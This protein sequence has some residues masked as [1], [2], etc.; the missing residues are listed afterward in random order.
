M[1]DLVV[2]NQAGSVFLSQRSPHVMIYQDSCKSPIP[3]LADC[4]DAVNSW[5]WPSVIDD[6]GEN[7]S[8][9]DR[10]LRP[11]GCYLRNFGTDTDESYRFFFNSAG[12]N[13]GLCTSDY[14]CLCFSLAGDAGWKT[15]VELISTPWFLPLN[16][17]LGMRGAPNMSTCVGDCDDDSDCAD[18]LKCFQR[19]ED[20]RV[21][22]CT[23][24]GVRAWD[25]CYNESVEEVRSDVMPY[26]AD[27]DNDGAVDLLLGHLDGRV[28]FYQRGLGN[29]LTLITESIV[30]IFGKSAMPVA[31]DLDG[32]GDLDLIVGYSGSSENESGYLEYFE[33]V[34]SRG[35][36]TLVHRSGSE[37]PFKFIVVGANLVPRIADWDG[38]GDVDLI[39][40][41]RYGGIYYFEQLSGIFV[42]R[43]ADG[44][45]FDGLNA[46]PFASITPL[47]LDG[48]GFLDLVS[49]CDD[50]YHRMWFYYSRHDTDD[51][52]HMTNNMNP[53]NN[54]HIRHAAPYFVDWDGDGDLDLLVGNLQGN[55]QY[56]QKQGDGTHV[57]LIGADN[58]FVGFEFG[59]SAK[60]QAVD[61]DGDGD[62]DVIVGCTEL[63]SQMGRIEYLERKANGSLVQMRGSSNPFVNISMLRASAP[64]AVDWDDDGDLDLIVPAH[65]A[66]QG[67]DKLFIFERQA[68]Q[69]LIRQV[70]GSNRFFAAQAIPD[71]TLVNRDID[72]LTS[73]VPLATDWNGD[74]RLD[75]LLGGIDGVV[76]LAKQH[77]SKGKYKFR[78]G[79]KASQIFCTVTMK[80]SDFGCPVVDLVNDPKHTYIHPAVL[81]FD[82]DGDL[83]LV[84]GK[85]FGNLGLHVSNGCEVTSPCAGNKGICDPLQG[86]CRCEIAYDG[87]DCSL[88]AQAHYRQPTANDPL[89]C[90][91]VPGFGSNEG[92][93]SSRGWS[94]DDLY[95][96]SL[97]KTPSLNLTVIGSGNCNCIETHFYG[98]D[99]TGRSS[100]ALGSCPPGLEL[101]K[102]ATHIGM[103]TCQACH[104]GRSKHQHGFACDNCGA[105]KYQSQE[106]MLSC[107]LCPPGKYQAGNSA[108]QCESC[109]PG[110]S[111]AAGS[112]SCTEC[113]SLQSSALAGPCQRQTW[114][115]I[116]YGLLCAVV[117]GELLAGLRLRTGPG[118]RVSMIG[119]PMRIEDV[120]TD[121]CRVIMKFSCSRQLH[122]MGRSSFRLR[123]RGTGN[124]FLDPDGDGVSK[125]LR[126][127]VVS[128]NLLELL[129][130]K[131]AS[132]NARRDTSSG[133]ACLP[134]LEAMIHQGWP[135]PSAF[136]APVLL[137]VAIV[138]AVTAQVEYM[139]A[140]VVA[141]GG[142]AFDCLLAVIM[143]RVKKPTLLQT[144]LQQYSEKLALENP[145]PV[146]TNR[147]P[148]R[149]IP[150]GCFFDLFTFFAAFIKD[151]NMYYLNPNIL[152]PLTA[153]HKM[154]FAEVVGPKK[155]EWF[156]S[157][158]WGTAI[159]YTVDAV[160]NHA[161]TVCQTRSWKDISYWICTF[162]NNQYRVSE[163][164]GHGYENSSFYLTLRSG[165]CLGTCMILDKDALPL[166]RSWCLFE[167]LQTILL[168]EMKLFSNFNGL[169]F[170]TNT[171]VVNY[172][173]ASVDVSRGIGRRLATLKLQDA[174]AFDAND[175]AMIHGLVRDTMGGFEPMN[176]KLRVHIR[177][178]LGVAQRKSAQDWKHIFTMLDH[179]EEIKDEEDIARSVEPI[180][181]S[182]I[183]FSEAAASVVNL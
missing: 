148:D 41:E 99:S 91:S 143:A 107:D 35:V 167:L 67:V 76:A 4:L 21:P 78:D 120:Y 175:Q 103:N 18:G 153:K 155:V 44:N 146:R 60:P 162:C 7:L 164:L 170:C 166:T 169:L 176:E 109:L 28:S 87:A 142:L 74:G 11:S 179:P 171:G 125:R 93:C 50:M 141:L 129:D 55:I 20:E 110:R 104:M 45:P 132:L 12:S 26:M 119:S 1:T 73:W 19:S 180:A 123:V 114:V 149:A 61:W 95:A 3:S 27:W 14:P 172:G 39:V 131:G 42:P 56:F 59:S 31:V 181:P 5:G 75:I 135:L 36:E 130:E 136:Q 133:V 161:M 122:M 29:N 147:G 112:T 57:E 177:H 25:Y 79:V 81:D 98:T 71:F 37:N 115:L 113:P 127:R 138:L 158:F 86:T 70:N 157:H 72:G 156:I 117:F 52:G 150:A 97:A 17:T 137:S 144:S 85:N 145:K 16:D 22:G 43:V 108:S 168:E 118:F 88:C 182:I 64:A 111:S 46:G 178:A 34:N 90:V 6:A 69:S 24:T 54:I 159:M 124:I 63:S 58:V 134:A 94:E 53:F 128:S 65:D 106:G 121:G 83:D 160:K 10:K 151:R 30:P 116:V 105:G 48:D 77:Y 126:G 163:E 101:R 49:A 152:L 183:G 40:S 33:K 84:V 100:C 165:L 51:F 15:P 47:D 102:S 2:G 23:G 62:L 66:A 96:K 80:R 82:G 154:S 9:I 32:D 89:K 92:V 173:S 8:V 38:D 174:H 13:T 139:E 68:D 140:A